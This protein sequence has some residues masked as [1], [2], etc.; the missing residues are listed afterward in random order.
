MRKALTFRYFTDATLI[1]TVVR[2]DAVFKL[3]SKQASLDN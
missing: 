2:R 3:S 1:Q